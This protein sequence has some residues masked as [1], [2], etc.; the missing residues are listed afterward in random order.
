MNTS[1]ARQFS[2]VFL[3]VVIHCISQQDKWEYSMLNVV[4]FKEYQ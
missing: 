2:Y 3:Q 4:Y 1:F